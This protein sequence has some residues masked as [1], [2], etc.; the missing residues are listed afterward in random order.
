MSRCFALFWQDG[1]AIRPTSRWF[2]NPSDIR[3]DWQSD[4]RGSG[5]IAS[6][7][8]WNRLSRSREAPEANFVDCS[9]FLDFVSPAADKSPGRLPLALSAH[10]IATFM[11]IGGKGIS[12]HDA[13]NT[14]PGCLCGNDGRQRLLQSL[15]LPRGLWPA[16]PL[17][18]LWTMRAVRARNRRLR[19]KGAVRPLRER[20]DVWRV[21]STVPRLLSPAKRLAMALVWVRM[22]RGLYARVVERSARLLRPL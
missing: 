6:R 4:L 9:D 8:S 10:G 12:Y 2:G 7:S 5:I 18:T 1:L 22:W 20:P 21:R 15:R 19:A 17:C 11:P 16:W 3:S 13:R 14:C